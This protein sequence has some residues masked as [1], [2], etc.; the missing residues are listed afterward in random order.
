MNQITP[1]QAMQAAAGAGIVDVGRLTSKDPHALRLPNPLTF[2]QEGEV[3]KP[4]MRS[5]N[6]VLDSEDE[7][8][9]TAP[10]SSG[11][12]EKLP[13]DLRECF[14]LLGEAQKAYE[15]AEAQFSGRH[16]A[17]N[18]EAYTAARDAKSAALRDLDR[19]KLHWKQV[20]QGGASQ[21]D[22]ERAIRTYPVEC[23]NG[24][25]NGPANREKRLAE[26]CQNFPHVRKHL[27]SPQRKK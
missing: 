8:I 21:D 24:L 25:L 27:P 13:Q 11:L 22:L 19:I 9:L 15:A 12:P 16:P 6:P 7:E 10:T 17:I 23:Q 26:L 20:Q 14:R 3:S 2:E 1:E 5:E 18:R 4:P